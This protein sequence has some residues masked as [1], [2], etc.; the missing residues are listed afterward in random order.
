MT[1]P[2]TS[3]PLGFAGLSAL[4][5]DVSA[6]L[7]ALELA[8]R[9]SPVPVKRAPSLPP[10]YRQPPTRIPGYSAPRAA[11]AQTRTPAPAPNSSSSGQLLMTLVVVLVLAA[12]KLIGQSDQKRPAPS[13]APVSAPPPRAAAPSSSS[14]TQYVWQPP[15]PSAPATKPRAQAPA[16]AAAVNPRETQLAKLKSRIETGRKRL[17]ALERRLKP[18][19]DQLDALQRRVQ[20]IS[21][22]LRQLDLDRGAG[23]EVDLDSYNAQVDNHN[24]LLRKLKALAN[25]SRADFEEYETLSR[26]DKELVA[27]YNSLI[28]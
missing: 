11:T 14:G 19:S 27:E 12:F 25:S 3:E 2:V 21:S 15:S 8:A 18:I 24:E 17:E 4:E 1:S 26:Q 16:P 5:S 20:A 7:K 28:K 9:S 6:E 23:L 22:N 10:L 13:P